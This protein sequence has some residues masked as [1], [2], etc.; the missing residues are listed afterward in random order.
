VTAVGSDSNGIVTTVGSDSNGIVTTVGSRQQWDRDNSGFWQQ[1]NRDNSGSHPV[2]PNRRVLEKI[3]KAEDVLLGERAQ[4]RSLSL[5][6]CAQVRAQVNLF[7]QYFFK[8][9]IVIVGT[10]GSLIRY[11]LYRL[12]CPAHGLMV[13]VLYNNAWLH[14]ILW[15]Q[16]QWYGSIC[17]A[18]LIRSQSTWWPGLN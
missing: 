12:K 18:F 4:R 16:C 14:Y 15:S 11:V 8:K 13:I 10:V 7:S 9:G 3:I 2:S 1:W 6:L 5:L 17:L